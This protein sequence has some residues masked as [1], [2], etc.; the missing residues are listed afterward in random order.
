ML[1][2]LF[3]ITHYAHFEYLSAIITIGLLPVCLQIELQIRGGIEDD[4]KIIF[5]IYQ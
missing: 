1:A 5:L 3:D 2:D 4:S